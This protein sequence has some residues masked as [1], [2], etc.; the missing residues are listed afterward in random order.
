M[1]TLI[2][3]IWI[4]CTYFV[5]CYFSCVSCLWDLVLICFG[6]GCLWVLVVWCLLLLWCIACWLYSCL[7]CVMLVDLSWFWW[8]LFLFAVWY[9][10]WVFVDSIVFDYLVGFVCCCDWLSNSAWLILFSGYTVLFDCV[11]TAVS[12]SFGTCLVVCLFGD[13]FVAFGL[14]FVA[15]R[16]GLH[17]PTVYLLF[18][19]DLL[20]LLICMWV[21]CCFWGVMCHFGWLFIWW[22]LCLM[23][24]CFCVMLLIVCWLRALFVKLLYLCWVLLVVSVFVSRY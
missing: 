14:S 12:D 17:L 8:E 4:W 22:Q 18:D 6:A 3:W 15:F 11:L 24:F 9:G 16:R 19:F 7:F 5:V 21:C 23:L 10:R 13:L 2:R 1:K 20:E